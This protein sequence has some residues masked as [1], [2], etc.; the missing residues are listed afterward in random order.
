MLRTA[1]RGPASQPRVWIGQDETGDE[2]DLCLH[3]DVDLPDATGTDDA[4]A[5]PLL[6]RNVPHLARSYLSGSNSSTILRAFPLGL[7]LGDLILYTEYA[8]SCY[9]QVSHAGEVA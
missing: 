2:L 6:R 1:T 8:G 7:Q 4:A 9:R 3:V 5:G